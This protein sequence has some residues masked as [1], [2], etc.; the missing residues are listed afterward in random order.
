MEEGEGE[1]MKKDLCD[2][3]HKPIDPPSIILYHY[4]V[5]YLFCSNRCLLMWLEAKP[6]DLGL[7]RPQ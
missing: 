3:C 7:V 4:G 5:K 6:N 2:E 1:Q